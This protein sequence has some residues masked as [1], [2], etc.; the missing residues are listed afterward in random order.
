MYSILLIDIIQ[1][2]LWNVL[3]SPDAASK[4]NVQHKN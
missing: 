3:S 2:T 4:P 1:F